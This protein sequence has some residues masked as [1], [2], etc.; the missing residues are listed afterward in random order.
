LS[1]LDKIS[2][3]LL[4]LYFECILE[5]LEFFPLRNMRPLIIR[6]PPFPWP[7]YGGPFDRLW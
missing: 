1:I 4:I 6:E 7:G 2:T 5:K 3:C